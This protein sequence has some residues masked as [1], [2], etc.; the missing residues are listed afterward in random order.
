MQIWTVVFECYLTYP[1]DHHHYELFMAFIMSMKIWIARMT[2][3]KTFSKCIFY[4][5][6]IQNVNGQNNVLIILL[7]RMCQCSKD[8]MLKKIIVLNTIY[9]HIVSTALI[10]LHKVKYK[11]GNVDLIFYKFIFLFI[12]QIK[13]SRS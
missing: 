2:T 13:V 4:K 5:I 9:V 8:L 3:W 11:I 10:Y 12:D 7:I 1:I 6:G